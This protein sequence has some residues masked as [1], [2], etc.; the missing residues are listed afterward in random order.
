[1]L[2]CARKVSVS[3][4][5]FFFLGVCVQSEVWANPKKLLSMEDLQAEELVKKDGGG[6]ILTGTSYTSLTLGLWSLSQDGLMLPIPGTHGFFLPNYSA[7][8]TFMHMAFQIQ[9]HIQR[10][11]MQQQ[12]QLQIQQQQQ[13]LQMQQ[14]QQLQLQLQLQQQLQQ[15]QAQAAFLASTMNSLAPIQL[16][17]LGATGFTE[18][19][20]IFTPVYPPAPPIQPFDPASSGIPLIHDANAIAFF[21][22]TP[23]QNDDP[24]EVITELDHEDENSS[25]HT[26]SHVDE[27]APNTDDKAKHE[28]E[29]KKG[30]SIKVSDHLSENNSLEP[31]SPVG[32]A[33]QDDHNHEDDLPSNQPQLQPDEEGEKDKFEEEKAAIPEPEKDKDLH[34]A[35]NDKEGEEV[36]DPNAPVVAESDEKDSQ[37]DKGKELPSA[38]ITT[39]PA[40]PVT[41]SNHD[42]SDVHLDGRD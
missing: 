26:I 31:V 27:V 28:D 22:M 5:L 30:E 38:G 9:I 25:G 21:G 36:T 16:F 11:Q 32:D 17:T 1:M 14:Q 33:S 34:L 4:V 3:F 35:S 7:A 37:D 41:S 12:Q 6:Y 23:G 13:Q 24:A 8:F 42:H 20:V 10:Q 19:N 39:T 2:K 40:L 18:P 29:N 15:Q